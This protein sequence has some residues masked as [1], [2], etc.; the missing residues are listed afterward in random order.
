[1]GTAEKIIY[2]KRYSYQKMLIQASKGM[3]FITDLEKLLNLIVHIVKKHIRTKSASIFYYDRGK[4][5]FVLKYRRG[6]NKRPVGYKIERDHPLIAW[7]NERRFSVLYKELECGS[8]DGVVRE[9]GVAPDTFTYLREELRYLGCEVCVPSFWKKEL[10]GFLILGEKFSGDAYAKEELDLLTA[11]SNG[12]AVAIEN[13]RNFM[14]LERFREKERESYFQTVLALAKT[15]D[16]KDTYTRGHLDKVTKY[17]MEVFEQ[18]LEPVRSGINK[19]EL[20]TS[21]LLH[22]IGK[23]GVPD[24]LLNKDGKLTPEEWSIMRQHP[25]IGARII[26]PVIKLKKVGRIIKHHQERYDG[27]G[28]PD[29]LRGEEIPIESRIIAVVDAYHA[30]IFD[31]PYR[32]A[33][34]EELALSELKNNAGTQFD[35]VI[36][37]AFIK[38]W[39][40]G[41]IRK[42]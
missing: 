35:P 42:A 24:S 40:K 13:A 3:V 38:A 11:L 12:V 23:I 6:E 4:D 30:M 1:M 17:G 37:E 28:Y 39:G 22:D 2:E 20:E 31:R 19:E 36:V 21:L 18:L 29:G 9:K 41:R 26:K 5:G 33:L 15:V 32:K 14:E 34:S 7:L 16:E 10:L 25:E 27:T 8:R